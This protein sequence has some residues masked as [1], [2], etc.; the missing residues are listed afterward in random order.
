MKQPNL[1]ELIKQIK[2][3]IKDLKYEPYKDLQF[4]DY[5]ILDDEQNELITLQN[6]KSYKDKQNFAG[7]C[8]DL[9]HIAL[10]RINNK[11]PDLKIQVW[12]GNN[13]KEFKDNT[14]VFILIKNSL[15]SKSKNLIVDPSL[16]R[17]E[18]EK[19]SL[20]KKHSLITDTKKFEGVVVYND[21]IMDYYDDTILF[22]DAK[23]NNRISF[24]FHGVHKM[25]G[26]LHNRE[27]IDNL[28]QLEKLTENRDFLNFVKNELN[29]FKISKKPQNYEYKSEIIYFEK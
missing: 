5:S 13:Q 11:F 29:D 19:D 23:T 3:L 26:L 9:S 24:F 18:I 20:Y 27:V 10:Q 1:N 6:I 7:D 4:S 14:H 16:Q 12:L 2:E 28:S 22:Y 25:F 21:K 15:L 17:I 8:E